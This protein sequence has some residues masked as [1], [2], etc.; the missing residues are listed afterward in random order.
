MGT[1]IN[2][3]EEVK[4]LA[5]ISFFKRSIIKIYDSVSG[6]YIKKIDITSVSLILGKL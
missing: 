2:C 1:F 6:S 5:V 4:D 3:I